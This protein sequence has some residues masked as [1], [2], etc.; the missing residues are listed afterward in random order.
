M[1]NKQ[2]DQKSSAFSP[3]RH[4][5]YSVWFSTKS[6][7]HW[8]VVCWSGADVESTFI[9]HQNPTSY[10]GRNTTS[11]KLSLM[12]KSKHHSLVRYLLRSNFKMSFIT[13]QKTTSIRRWD[14][15]VN[16]RLKNLHFQPIYN[17]TPT[18][19]LCRNTSP[20]WHSFWPNEKV[21]LVS[22][23]VEK[24]VLNRFRI[25]LIFNQITTWTRRRI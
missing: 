6:H 22:Y 5:K 11:K 10:L 14:Q 1:T 2:K 16:R 24:H 23:D 12:T 13:N 20:Q 3:F 25:S 19:Y 21:I 9:S 8:D 17:Q 7:P 18:S 4:S 15:V